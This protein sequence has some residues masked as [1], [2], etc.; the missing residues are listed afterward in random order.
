MDPK[1]LKFA[2]SHEWVALEGD[3][4]TIGVSQFAVDQLSDLLLIELPPVG[5]VFEAGQAFG[6][7]ESV[8]NVSDLYAPVA[9]EVVAVNE[10]VVKDVQVLGQGPYDQGWLIKLKVKDP[11][12]IASLMDHDAYE[13]KVAAED[14]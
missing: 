6:Q 11:S 8:K 4:A 3:V 5:K 13:A 7:I 9:G 10:A 14:H 12:A 1:T 2:E